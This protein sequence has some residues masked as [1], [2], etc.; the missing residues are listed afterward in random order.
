MFLDFL[1]RYREFGPFFIRIA[2]GLVMIGHG[3]QKLFGAFGGGGLSGTAEFFNQIDIAP[4]LF[5]ATIVAVVE[6]FGGLFVLIGFLT[7]F[8][9][10]FIGMTMF[11]AM[12]WVH[13]QNGFFLSSRGIEFTLVLFCM[14]VTL[15]L[16]GPGRI[17]V[18]SMLKSSRST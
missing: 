8:A 4:G 10:I 12:T 18:E 1:D 13:L 17:S 9:S 16:V 14:A 6:T 5:W 15:I 11:V 2:L 7:R 3:S